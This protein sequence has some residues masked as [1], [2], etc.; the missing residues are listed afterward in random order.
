MSSHTF[1]YLIK[2]ATGLCI[3]MIFNFNLYT[4]VVCIFSLIFRT[5]TDQFLLAYMHPVLIVS[6]TTIMTQVYTEQTK[7]QSKYK[8]SENPDHY[9][10]N[11][12]YTSRTSEL[13]SELN[14][15]VVSELTFEAKQPGFE[16]RGEYMLY[17]VAGISS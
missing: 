9:K 14:S 13:L 15:Y 7:F 3:G 17:D 11:Y 5:A 16:P 4:L 1:S 6:I 10:L 12:N 8:Q 2:I